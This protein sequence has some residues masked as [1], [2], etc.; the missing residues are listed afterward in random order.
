MKMREKTREKSLFHETVVEVGFP[1]DVEK[2]PE[3]FLVSIFSHQVAKYT[4]YIR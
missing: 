4:L 1:A 2:L 3:P